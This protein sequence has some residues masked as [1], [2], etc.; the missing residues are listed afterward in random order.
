MSRYLV[1]EN[2]LITTSSNAPG[3]GREN[4]TS[5]ER[6]QMIG[7]KSGMTY[8]T[9]RAVAGYVL[10][11]RI[12][13]VWLRNQKSS[14]ARKAKPAKSAMKLQNRK[15]AQNKLIGLMNVN[16]TEKD[17]YITLSYRGVPPFSEEEAR[18]DM[19]NYLKR[20][21]RWRGTRDMSELKYIYVIEDD[22]DGEKIRI[23]H[24][25]V[26]SGMDRNEAERIWDLGRTCS[27]MLEADEDGF[28]SIAR[29]LTKSAKEP[30]K[31]SWCG[32]QN[33]KKPDI[34]ISDNEITKRDAEN[35]IHNREL[36]REKLQQKESEFI[37]NS[38]TIKTNEYIS[39]AY[40][41]AKFRRISKC[42]NKSKK[43]MNSY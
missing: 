32:S 19:Q 3:S 31:K 18:K 23:H 42:E 8:R 38:M 29:Y 41:A 25:L 27:R 39:G 1:K 4:A 5:Q 15:N 11:L 17:I 22:Y 30:G 10:D 35:A 37:L 20:I 28:E 40:V 13:P 14:R 6:I 9:K 2:G 36:F 7:H 16:F 12:Y 34:T 24:H 33:L 21:K 26:M 43:P